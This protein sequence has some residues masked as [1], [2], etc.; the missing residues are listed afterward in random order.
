MR[1]RTVGAAYSLCMVAGALMSAPPSSEAGQWDIG[2]QTSL[3]MRYFPYSP[4]FPNQNKT[5]VSPSG[6]LEPEFIYEWDG[7]SDRLTLTTFVRLDADDKRRIHSDFREANWLH[8]SSGWDVLVGIGK[9]FWGVTES[10]HLVD[11]INQT[12]VVEDISGE[13]KLGQPMV[14]FNIEQSWGAVNFF[15]LPGFRTR[16]FTA[17]N[18]RLHGPLPVDTSNP[19]YESDKDNRHVDWAIR[20]SRSFDDLDVAISHFQGTS[21]EARLLLQNRAA[22]TVLVP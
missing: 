18:A 20:W 19:G 16:T 4:E 10:A 11:I 7:G 2:G 3:E 9:V 13:E 5:T 8:I 22:R 21:R 15:V 14:N 6:T 17:D 12:D 1:K